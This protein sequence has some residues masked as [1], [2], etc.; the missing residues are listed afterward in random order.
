MKGALTK[1]EKLPCFHDLTRLLPCIRLRRQPRS[2]AQ[3]CASRPVAFGHASGLLIALS[4]INATPVLAELSVV[5]VSTT[6]IFS[7]TNLLEDAVPVINIRCIR[8]E[9]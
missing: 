6:V 5:E 8:F 1:A 4:T 7:V 2:V 9:S 3:P